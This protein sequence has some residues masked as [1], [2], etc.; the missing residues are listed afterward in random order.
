ML[1]IFKKLLAAAVEIMAAKAE[2]K[3]PE[4]DTRSF[5]DLLSEYKDMHVEDKEWF[6]DIAK[7]IDR[8]NEIIWHEYIKR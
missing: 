8:Q 5:E 1:E 2:K 7:N 6:K 4:E 3:G